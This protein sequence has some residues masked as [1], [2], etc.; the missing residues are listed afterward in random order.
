MKF[1][2][3]LPGHPQATAL[4][5]GGNELPGMT[6][7]RRRVGDPREGPDETVHPPGKTSEPMHAS[8]TREMIND[9]GRHVHTEAGATLVHA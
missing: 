1:Q 4:E 3:F 6:W 9:F 7:V 2:G 8:P 5:K